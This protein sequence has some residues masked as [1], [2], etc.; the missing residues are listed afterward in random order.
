MPPRTPASDTNADA[1]ET[2]PEAPAIKWVSIQRPP[3]NTEIGIYLGF[4]SIS[5][6]YPFDVPVRM[7]ADMVAYYR[8]QKE[9]Q[10]FPGPDGLPVIT[11]ANQFTILDAD[12][13]A[14]S[15]STAGLAG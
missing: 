10:A 1:A 7:P 15:T 2:T 11:Y 6:V 13:P 4:N 8:N 3:G 14:P 5:G 9:A 12:P